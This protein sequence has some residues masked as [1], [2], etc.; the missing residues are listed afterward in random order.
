MQH[1]IFGLLVSFALIQPGIIHAQD[2]VY[3]KKSV[4]HCC[5]KADPEFEKALPADA[6]Y[7]MKNIRVVTA[8]SLTAGEVKLVIPETKIGSNLDIQIPLASIKDLGKGEDLMIE[9]GEVYRIS[10]DNKK[11]LVPYFRAEKAQIIHIQ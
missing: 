8:N 1:L 9:I 7:Q 3:T 10:S 2:K 5:L 11:E 4:V 6:R